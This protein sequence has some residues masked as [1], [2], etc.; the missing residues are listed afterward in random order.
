MIKPLKNLLL[1]N[2]KA[3]DLE[4]W[5]A[6]MGTQDYPI[7][8]NDD[9]GLTLTCFMARPNLVPYAFV[10]EKGKTVDFQKLFKS[11][12]SKLVDAVN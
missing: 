6:A 11:V 9:P 2:Q 7:Y 1:W 10:W 4:T 3:D 5:Y 8:S 12:T